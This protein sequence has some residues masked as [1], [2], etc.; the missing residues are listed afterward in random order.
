MEQLDQEISRILEEAEIELKSF[1]KY[2]WL[3]NL[4]KAHKMVEYW[5]TAMSYQRNNIKEDHVLKEKEHEIGP[6]V[7]IYQGDRPMRP[8]NQM[9]R[10][11]TK[12]K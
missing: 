7:D 2:W 4:H 6:D 10:A 1:P 5:R 8:Q 12:R 11:M 9:R 3:E